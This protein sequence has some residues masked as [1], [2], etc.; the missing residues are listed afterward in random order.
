MTFPGLADRLARVREEVGR[1]V[2]I[3]AVT[4]GHG[5]DAVRAA[6]AAGLTDV[7]ENRV[8]EATAK[9]DATADVPVS[10]HLIG[11]LQTNKAKMVPGRFAMVH[12]VDSTKVVDALAAACA[13]AGS[14]LNVL[15]Q[16]NVAGEEQ[17]SGCDPAEASDLLGH[18]AGTRHLAVV[19][20]M[21]MAPFTDDAT[22]QRGTF[23]ALRTL[24]D[25][26]ATAALPLPE[27]SMGMS[28]D[29]QA[30]AAEGATILRL[31]TILFGERV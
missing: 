26:I 10:W 13:K 7:G 15:L 19:G 14:T 4:K 2:R 9:Q 20:L 28:G 29:W 25:R 1:P 11:H 27:L 8:Q 31:G 5:P 18:V 24:R 30:A 16:V 6:Q 3:V 21:T 23:A 17:K 12:S 22:V